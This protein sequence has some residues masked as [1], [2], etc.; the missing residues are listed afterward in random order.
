MK[1]YLLLLFLFFTPLTYAQRDNGIIIGIYKNKINYNDGVSPFSIL[2]TIFGNENY[3]NNYGLNIGYQFNENLDLLLDASFMNL[4]GGIP[5]GENE[6]DQNMKTIKMG[7]DFNYRIIKSSKISPKLGLKCGFF[8]FSDLEGKITEN[9]FVKSNS[10]GLYY[11]TRFMSWDF[12][13]TLDLLASFKFN[14]LT[15]DIG[16]NLDYLRFSAYKFYSDAH[17]ENRLNLGI[18]FGL[19]YFLPFNTSPKTETP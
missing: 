16:A 6:N 1:R 9:T 17:K 12:Y 5:Y 15:L 13:S 19:S 14:H 11:D 8:P 2:E 10:S 4:G 18:T 7:I 3:F